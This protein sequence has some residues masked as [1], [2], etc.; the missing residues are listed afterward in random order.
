MQI[1][2]WKVKKTWMVRTWT[3]MKKNMEVNTRWE[4]LDKE[5]VPLILLRKRKRRRKRR[6]RRSQKKWRIQ[7]SGST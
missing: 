5:L 6:E 1:K 4:S 7:V 3:T 2:I